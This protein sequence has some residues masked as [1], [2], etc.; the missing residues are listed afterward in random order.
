MESSF[1]EYRDKSG[2]ERDSDTDAIDDSIEESFIL[3]T[4][5][6]LKKNH[7]VIPDSEESLVDGKFM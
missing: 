3:T 1:L 6:T 2:V 7:T 4:K 5:T